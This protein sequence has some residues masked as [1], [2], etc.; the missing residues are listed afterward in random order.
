MGE[1]Q[2]AHQADER[3]ERLGRSPWMLAAAREYRQPRFVFS[4]PLHVRRANEADHGLTSFWLDM[5]VN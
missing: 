5:T 1:H 2:A 3:A 4:S